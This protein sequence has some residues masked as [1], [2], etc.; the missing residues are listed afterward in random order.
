MWTMRSSNSTAFCG[1]S[2]HAPISFCPLNPHSSPGS[3]L[4]V[5]TADSAIM[6]LAYFLNAAAGSSR[7]CAMVTV[8]AMPPGPSNRPPTSPV[9]AVID[10]LS[11]TPTVIL[12]ACWSSTSAVIRTLGRIVCEHATVFGGTGARVVGTTPYADWSPP[13]R[14]ADGDDPTALEGP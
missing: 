9:P 12:G 4:T 10:H 5:L 13:C 7:V 14:V 1:V 11:G 6:S 2:D 3:T 8:A